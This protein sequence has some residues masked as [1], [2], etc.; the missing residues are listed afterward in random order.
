MNSKPNRDGVFH[1]R[2]CEKTYLY[3]IDKKYWGG[4]MSLEKINKKI[5]NGKTN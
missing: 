3:G 5:Q 1:M 4:M 2:G